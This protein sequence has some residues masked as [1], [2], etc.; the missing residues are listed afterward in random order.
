M[1]QPF[2][3]FVVFAEM[4]TGS[5]FLET[6]LNAYDGVTCHGEA[7]NPHFIGYPNR[8]EILGVTQAMR[9]A[10]PLRLVTT[11][12]DQAGGLGGFRFFHD[13]DPRVLE[14]LLGDPRCAK[15]VLTRNP[16]ESYVSW[17]IA[18]ATGQW[19]LTD[20]RRRKDSRVTFDR[21]E[22]EAH[23]GA[24]QE[25]Q[26]RVMNALQVTG[27]TAFYVDYEDLQSVEVM[28]G[29]AR[30]LG[31]SDQ[32]DSLDQSLK[33]QNPEPMSEKVTNFEA[34]AEA[35]AR[36]DRFNLSR[37]PN[38]EP[39]R[40]AQVP[41]FVAAARAPLL[42]MPVRSGPEAQVMAWLAA[43]DGV[44]PEDLHSKFSQ[45]TMRQ[46]KR[47]HPGHRSFT[48]LRHPLARA[49]DAF[50]RRI[51]TVGPG[52]YAEIR[53]TL[54]KQFKLPIPGR[55]PGED[56][57]RRAH[58]A[59]FVAFLEFLKKNLNG[60]TGIRVDAGWASQ[61]SVLEG[62]ANFS[63]PDLILRE[64]DMPRTLPDLASQLGCASV[65][66]VPEADPAGP[67][68]LADIYDSEIEKLAAQVYQRDYIMFGFE[69]WG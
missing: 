10:D 30:W 58:R 69:S 44:G 46:W 50:C 60:Q 41:S 64:E 34:M 29:L 5:N 16:A 56:Y 49:H 8:S 61:A 2:D 26:L 25:F 59:A 54:R 24:L 47:A 17:K 45:K 19:K 18:Q 37:T 57:D 66:Q 31:V 39:R 65:P 42:Y 36:L 21:D 35:L 15:I 22:F 48:V 11:I 63:L 13:H 52:G 51:L 12:R 14:V 27:Q 32:L 53:K 40:G 43:L 67:F 62:F 68:D 33:K 3:Y 4:R 7:F 20:G 6:N 28:N 38:F 9:D 1:S 55:E 23:L